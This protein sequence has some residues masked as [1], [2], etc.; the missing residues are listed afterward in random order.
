[1]LRRRFSVDFVKIF[2]IFQGVFCAYFPPTDQ[3]VGNTR[4]SRG[5]K[6]GF[7]GLFLSSPRNFQGFSL[8]KW[9]KFV[10]SGDGI[11]KKVKGL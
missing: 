1:L 8:K 4:F 7:F 9:D 11:I 3:L 6:T 5:Q 2:R 10:K